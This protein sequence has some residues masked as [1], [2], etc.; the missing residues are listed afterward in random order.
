MHMHVPILNGLFSPQ[1]S[2]R[3][4]SLHLWRFSVKLNCAWQEHLV[5]PFARGYHWQANVRQHLKIDEH[6]AFGVDE[7]LNGGG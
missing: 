1:I 5:E 7:F 2:A 6:W 3:G 4:H